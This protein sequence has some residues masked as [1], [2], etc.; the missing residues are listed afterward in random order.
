EKY[1]QNVRSGYA[2]QA[3]GGAIPLWIF[4][5]NGLPLQVRDFASREDSEGSTLAQPGDCFPKRAAV[6]VNRLI[7]TIGID[8]DAGVLELRNPAEQIVGQY[9]HVGADAAE[10]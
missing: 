1:W 5:A 9:F 4:D 2:G 6:A 10:G 3:R 7:G 8:K